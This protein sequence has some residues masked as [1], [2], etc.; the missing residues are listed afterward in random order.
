MTIA[1]CTAGMY[2]LINKQTDLNLTRI[3]QLSNTYINNFETIGV[4]KR[5]KSYL[6]ESIFPL[7]LKNEK[8]CLLSGYIL[9]CY[10][11]C[12]FGEI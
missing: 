9:H 1:Q 8:A 2:L 10:C 4:S 6:E 12:S 5:Y 7:I 11:R 3:G